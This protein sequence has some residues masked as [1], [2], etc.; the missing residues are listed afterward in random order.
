VACVFWGY[1]NTAL[2]EEY[3][4]VKKQSTYVRGAMTDQQ[5]NKAVQESMDEC[6]AEWDKKVASGKYR[7]QGMEGC[8]GYYQLLI[9]RKKKV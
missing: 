8:G 2:M 4:M 7:V 9:P 3:S 6:Q 1:I 5:F